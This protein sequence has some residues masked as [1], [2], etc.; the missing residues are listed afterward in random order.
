VTLA[1][2]K[3]KDGSEFASLAFEIRPHGDSA[4]L[5]AVTDQ[6]RRRR[7]AVLPPTRQKVLDALT[8]CAEEGGLAFTK[9]CDSSGVARATFTR[10]VN[11]L[12]SWGLIEKRGGKWVA[13]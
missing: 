3:Q 7:P 13:L 5:V 6:E 11:D 8:R 10:C 9:W 12:D 2:L 4:V 1:C